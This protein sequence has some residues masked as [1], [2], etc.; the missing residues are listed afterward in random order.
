MA[1]WKQAVGAS[2]DLAEVCERSIRH[3]IAASARH[4]LAAHGST[5]A[6]RAPAH[7]NIGSSRGSILRSGREALCRARSLAASRSLLG[8]QCKALPWDSDTSSASRLV[9]EVV[10]QDSTADDAQMVAV[11]CAEQS[12]DQAR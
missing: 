5:A 8:T 2:H 1:A 11:S 6:C 4:T 10:G 9:G 3:C 12:C 7:T